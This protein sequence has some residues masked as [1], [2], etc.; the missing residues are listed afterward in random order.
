MRDELLSKLRLIAGTL[1]AKSGS[2]ESLLEKALNQTEALTRWVED[3]VLESSEI[4]DE[5]I[6]AAAFRQAFQDSFNEMEHS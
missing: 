4:T 3:N 2:P 6:D 5:Q 1:E